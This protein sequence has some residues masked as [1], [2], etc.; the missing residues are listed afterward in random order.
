MILN[1]LVV[2]GL[3]F[4]CVVKGD[5]IFGFHVESK[6]DSATFSCIK[7]LNNATMAVVTALDKYSAVDFNACDTM[8]MAKDNGMNTVDAF[9]IPCPTCGQSAA[10]Q[11]SLMTNNLKSNCASA[12]SGRVWLDLGSHQFW[13]T[14]WNDIGYVKNQQW[15]T[16]LVDACSANG[17]VKQCGILS[18]STEWKYIFGSD[19]YSY[20]PATKFPLWYRA[21]D[22]SP[23]YD[24]NSFMSFGG[25]STTPYAKQY[26]YYMTI[27]NTNIVYSDWMPTL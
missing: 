21:L 16:T 11:I 12:W 27:C 7:N 25:F 24:K 20:A 23:S 9:L 4:V 14:P 3:C 13:P 1:L 5:G 19:S 18:S 22:G 17:D 6:M 8:K 2:V 10:Q 26:A 15:F